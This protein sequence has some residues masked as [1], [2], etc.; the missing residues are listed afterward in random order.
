MSVRLAATCA[1]V[2]WLITGLVAMIMAAGNPTAING[3]IGA[4]VWAAFWTGVTIYVLVKR[5][6]T[7]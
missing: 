5:A 1:V 2:L 4:G 3:V 7:Y 6:R